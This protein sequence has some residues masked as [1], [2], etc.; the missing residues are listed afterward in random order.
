M[1]IIEVSWHD[2]KQCLNCTDDIMQ[3][4]VEILSYQMI[5]LLSIPIIIYLIAWYDMMGLTSLDEL[6]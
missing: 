5:S 2:S 1:P 6:L 4:S 3:S